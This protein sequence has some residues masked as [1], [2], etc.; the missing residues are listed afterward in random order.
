[1]KAPV[2]Y[3]QMDVTLSDILTGASIFGVCSAAIIGLFVKLSKANIRIDDNTESIKE[4][5]KTQE[6]Q[7]DILADLKTLIELHDSRLGAVEDAKAS[8]N[9]IK[10]DITQMIREEGRNSEKLSSN[11]KSLE[12]MAGSVIR[13][14]ERIDQLKLN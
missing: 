14:H 5:K 9:Q 13:I 4:L 10:E 2:Y 12:T 1:M 3:S 11:Q 7:Q 8:L 6:S